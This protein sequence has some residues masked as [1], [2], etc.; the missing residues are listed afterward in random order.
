MAG[1]DEDEMSISNA[2][3]EAE[4]LIDIQVNPVQNVPHHDVIVRYEDIYPDQMV[5]QVVLL[6]Y[7][8]V[9]DGQ[10]EVSTEALSWAGSEGGAS[11]E[12]DVPFLRPLF[13]W[14]EEEED[15]LSDDS[16][17]LSESTISIPEHGVHDLE[18][19]S[20]PS[21]ASE[22][23]DDTSVYSTIISSA[24]G[25]DENSTNVET[26]S[27]I[28]DFESLPGDFPPSPGPPPPGL[29]KDAIEKGLFVGSDTF[30]KVFIYYNEKDFKKR[31]TWPHTLPGCVNQLWQSLCRW[32]VSYK[33]RMVLPIDE[34]DIFQ[35]QRILNTQSQWK[36]RYFMRVLSAMGITRAKNVYREHEIPAD[37]I[38]NIYEQYQQVNVH[39]GLAVH[40]VDRL[41]GTNCVTADGIPYHHIFPR[42]AAEIEALG[43]NYMADG[44]QSI[45]LNTIMYVMNTLFILGSFKLGQVA[46]LKP[47]HLRNAH[48]LGHSIVTR[49]ADF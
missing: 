23:S 45:T 34:G 16:L 47:G 13:Q 21:L 36:P 15:V 48:V 33:K 28:D 4:E 14:E 42:I 9:P 18:R 24:T 12:T 44:F 43:S 3:A 35:R 40:L 19:V 25:G 31:R 8:E 2:P 46:Y 30:S 5:Q 10:S 7:P 49:V 32:V 6:N 38:R 17:S 22:A 26:E 39:H 41:K 27:A 37:F 1:R 29:G 11:E 20:N